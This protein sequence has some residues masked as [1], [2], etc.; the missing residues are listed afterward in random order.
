M[1]DC[2][3]HSYRELIF[4]SEIYDQTLEMFEHNLAQLARS[5]TAQIAGDMNNLVLG[6]ETQSGQNL[7]DLYAA[8]FYVDSRIDLREYVTFIMQMKHYGAVVNALW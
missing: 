6:G 8:G 2:S 7:V 4:I 5:A 3:H 1:P